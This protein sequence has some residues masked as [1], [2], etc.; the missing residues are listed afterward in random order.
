[1]AQ[2]EKNI[3]ALI[4]L[5]D[6][7]DRMVFDHV[8][9]TLIELGIEVVPQLEA[10]WEESFNPL[11]QQRIEE[12]VNQIQFKKIC[13]DLENWVNSGAEK[14]IDG[15]MILTKYQ[16]PDVDE[17]KLLRQIELIRKDIW[18]ELNDERT[19]M[20]T[21]K[22]LN[23]IL[24]NTHGFSGNTTNYHAPGNNFLNTL[25]ESKKGNA[26]SLSALYITICQILGVTVY[27]VNLPEHF[28][29]AY[30]EESPTALLFKPFNENPVLFYM[31]PL[32]RGT[33]FG[34]QEIDV[35]LKRLNL[36]PEKSY[37][38]PCGNTEVVSVLIQN[39]IK[40]YREDRRKEKTAEL[41][42]LL[43]ILNQT[44]RF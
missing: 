11:L 18:I 31:N 8:R 20:E 16:Y 42:Y 15:W 7:E 27:G 3:K 4:T 24:F 32:N 23:H 10:A 34:R 37:F 9:S 28:I 22:V 38:E 29:L 14:L 12:I 25:L 13:S 35:F 39:L 36:K 19:A 30:K 43:K 41:E 40:A 1:M 2:D 6:D 21:V 17:Q 44:N 5:L 26:V 33:I